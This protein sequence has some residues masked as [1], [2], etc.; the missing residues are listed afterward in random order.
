VKISWM[1]ALL[2]Q[3]T[4]DGRL[5]GVYSWLA[6]GLR[7]RVA[8]GALLDRRGGRS[9]LSAGGCS[10]EK[11][12]HEHGLTALVDGVAVHGKGEPATCQAVSR[13]ICCYA[14]RVAP[15]ATECVSRASSC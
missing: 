2:G 10:R 3:R 4:F 15:A 1:N 7:G 9:R 8:G 12:Q 13:K 14:A 5:S 6:R 11:N